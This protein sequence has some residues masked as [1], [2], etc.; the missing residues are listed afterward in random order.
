MK[1][2]RPWRQS[3]VFRIIRELD[4]IN[5][6]AHRF[7]NDFFSITSITTFFDLKFVWLFLYKLCFE[8]KPYLL[9]CFENTVIMRLCLLFLSPDCEKRFFCNRFFYKR[10]AGTPE[11]GKSRRCLEILKAKLVSSQS[12]SSSGNTS[13]KW[14]EEKSKPIIIISKMGANHFAA[15]SGMILKATLCL[16]GR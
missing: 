14:T 7:W 11:M 3:V 9:D 8:I 16:Q 6:F 12:C 10:K 1:G 15:D 13:F 4:I 2:L 5:N